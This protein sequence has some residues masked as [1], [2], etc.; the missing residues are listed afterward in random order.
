LE[1]DASQSYAWRRY[2]TF[3]LRSKCR[4]GFETVFFYADG[5]AR[6]LTCRDRKVALIA[7]TLVFRERWAVK[8]V[9]AL[10]V[11]SAPLTAHLSRK[12][13][14]GKR[15]RPLC[16]TL[17]LTG[18]RNIIV[19]L[20]DSAIR[21]PADP[22]GHRLKR[23]LKQIPDRNRSKSPTRFPEDPQFSCPKSRCRNSRCRP[24]PTREIMPCRSEPSCNFG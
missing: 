19:H 3:G 7:C 4:T 18:E 22:T 15:S 2:F 24:N 13:R 12:K 10:A 17:L 14:L 16:A 5:G 6:A 9:A 11:P 1:L 23:R 20:T 8:G 21:W